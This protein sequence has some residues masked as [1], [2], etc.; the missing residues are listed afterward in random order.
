MKNEELALHP[1]DDDS[2]VSQLQYSTEAG[3]VEFDQKEL[4]EVTLD[5]VILPIKRIAIS[6]DCK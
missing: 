4:V 5:E 6:L 1:T 2:E 3:Q